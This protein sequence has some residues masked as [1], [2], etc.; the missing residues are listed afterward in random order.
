M[1]K[2]FYI[3]VKANLPG[4]KFDLYGSRVSIQKI[5]VSLPV[6]LEKLS[7]AE[8]FLSK[9]KTYSDNPSVFPYYVSAFLAAFSSVQEQV[10]STYNKKKKF[11]APIKAK[12]DAFQTKK[13]IKELTDLR[14]DEAHR[15]SIPLEYEVFL[16]P[17]STIRASLARLGYEIA[18]DG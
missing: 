18:E 4:K 11:K 16:K 15:K 14:N 1:K 5:R 3:E 6:G 8:H 9:I 7:E 2:S 17:S 10:R 13:I 12:L